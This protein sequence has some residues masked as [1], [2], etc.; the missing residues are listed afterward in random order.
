MRQLCTGLLAAALILGLMAVEPA[1]AK[2]YKMAPEEREAA[3]KEKKAQRAKSKK[4]GKAAPG[5]GQGGWVEVKPGEKIAK[6]NRKAKVDE[7][8]KAAEDKGKKNKKSKNA[9][10][11][12]PVVPAKAEA[13]KASKANKAKKAGS[14]EIVAEKKADKKVEKK[15]TRKTAS[16]GDRVVGSNYS[17]ERKV[18]A[19]STEV[20]RP[21]G[22]PTP[23]PAGQTDDL[24]SYSVSRPG[25]DKAPALPEVRHEVQPGPVDASKPI[26]TEH[27][28]GEGRF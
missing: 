25:P 2:V 10:A 8:A 4:S 3:L 17:G 16:H 19:S 23:A 27:K 11:G 22:A 15:P 9:A 24:N 26:G 7:L 21:G 28:T 14:Q 20:R 5:Q 6:K 12:A 1:Q 13:G 18:S